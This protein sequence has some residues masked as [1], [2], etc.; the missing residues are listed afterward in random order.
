VSLSVSLSLC[1]SVY[2]SLSVSLCVSLSVSVS[3][4]LSLSL[5]LSLSLFLCLSVSLSLSVS[6]AQIHAVRAV[7]PNKSNNEIS[8]VLQHFEN[9]VDKAVQAFLE[10]MG[11][12]EHAI[13]HDDTAFIVVIVVIVVIVGTNPPGIYIVY[14]E[15]AATHLPDIK[16]VGGGVGFYK[17]IILQMHVEQIMTFI[18]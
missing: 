2:L 6:P 16:V 18:S 13:P 4:S 17:K 7:V 15:C 10:G 8:L 14:V 1:L 5:C 9:S 3:L 11:T 12:R